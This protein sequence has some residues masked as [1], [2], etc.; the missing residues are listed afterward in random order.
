MEVEL[1]KLPKVDATKLFDAK[2][3]RYAL[4]K[5]RPIDCTPPRAP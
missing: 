2:K 3:P 1:K 4:P 5:A